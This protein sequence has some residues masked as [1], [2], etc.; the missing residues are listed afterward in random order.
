M[1]ACVRPRR[2]E[3]PTSSGSRRIRI[4]DPHEPGGRV[5]GLMRKHEPPGRASLDHLRRP[6]HPR[7]GRE[8]P[9]SQAEFAGSSCEWRPTGSFP[10]RRALRRRQRV[11]ARL[12]ADCSFDHEPPATVARVTGMMTCVPPGLAQITCVAF[13]GASPPERTQ[14]A[15]KARNGRSICEY[16]DSAADVIGPSTARRSPA[17]RGTGRPVQ[18]LA[19]ES[20]SSETLTSRCE[21]AKNAWLQAV[22]RWQDPDSNRG[23]HGLQTVAAKSRTYAKVLQRYGFEQHGT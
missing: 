2:G 10:P 7:D 19:R 16:T 13:L 6:A 20:L 8:H 14:P 22:L 23:H 18:V 1:V 12:Q 4:S 15:L 21:D 3:P 17:R 11:A 9:A 5:D